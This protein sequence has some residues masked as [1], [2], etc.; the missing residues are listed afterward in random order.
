[1]G[2]EER[3]CRRSYHYFCALCDDATI[4]TDEVNGVYRYLTK[5][6]LTNYCQ[7]FGGGVRKKDL[8]VVCGLFKVFFDKEVCFPFKVVFNHLFTSNREN[9]F[10]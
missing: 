9:V 6:F 8:K 4:E 3:A 1:M 10:L 7:G 2:C 5:Y